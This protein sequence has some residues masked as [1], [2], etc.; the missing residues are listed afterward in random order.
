MDDLQRLRSADLEL[1]VAEVGDDFEEASEGGDAG[2][3]RAYYS[4]ALDAA[5]EV[6][7]DQLTAIAHGHA[8]KLAARSRSRC[9]GDCAWIR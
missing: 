8:A 6:T 3:G 7:D 9:R 2:S 1:F 4:L 5:R